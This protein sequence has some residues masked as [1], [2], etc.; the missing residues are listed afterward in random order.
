MPRPE[1][2]A[3]CFDAAEPNCCCNFP[4]G[5]SCTRQQV[6]CPICSHLCEPYERRPPRCACEPSREGTAAEASDFRHA[7]NRPRFVE[8]RTQLVQE[9]RNASAT[10]V[11]NGN[12]ENLRLA[13]IAMRGQNEAARHDIGNLN[14]EILSYNMKAK[15]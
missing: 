3:E 5:H 2:S 9:R 1:L 13:T 14:P 12:F 7:G 4:Y 10:G 11:G 15:V 8:A 6:P